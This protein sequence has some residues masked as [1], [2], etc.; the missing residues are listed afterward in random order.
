MFSWLF[1][2]VCFLYG[3]CW[4]WGWSCFCRGSEPTRASEGPACSHVGIRLR[5]HATYVR[6]TLSA[7]GFVSF[8]W[9]GASKRTLVQFTFSLKANGLVDTKLQPSLTQSNKRVL[10][11]SYLLNYILW[12]SFNIIWVSTFYSVGVGSV[13]NYLNVFMPDWSCSASSCAPP[14]KDPFDTCSRT[15]IGL[16][17]LYPKPQ[18]LFFF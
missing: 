15:P 9:E 7:P 12:K 2:K 8:V 13:G 18:Q 17:Y 6:S 11:G 1:V 16:F 4:G 14:V 10:K 5:L 3:T